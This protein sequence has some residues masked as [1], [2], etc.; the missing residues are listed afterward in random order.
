M[1][2][3]SEQRLSQVHPVLSD[4]IHK[5]A[6]LCLD[7]G[8]EIRV[9]QGYRSY[10]QQLAL[11]AQ[12]RTTPGRIITNAKPEDSMHCY[13]L[14]VDIAPNLPNLPNWTPDWNALDTT[15]K[16]VLSIALSCDLAEGAN[17]RTFKDYPH[18]YPVELEA[19][20]DDDMK[21]NLTEGGV[22]AVW[23]SLNLGG[24]DGNA[25]TNNSQQA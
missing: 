2:P 12:G 6:A 17:W 10:A 15:W 3:V 21:Y 14:A 8:I 11:Y 24:Q 1:D 13:G 16:L 20:P 9:T 4:R 7:K 19:D 22:R 23:A 18:L 25:D 5:L